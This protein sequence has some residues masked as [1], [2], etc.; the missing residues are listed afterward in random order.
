M[1]AQGVLEELKGHS[2]S[3]SLRSTL[4]PEVG[5]ENRRAAPPT[6]GLGVV[7]GLQMP[8]LGFLAA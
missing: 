7:E 6:L 4:L 8:A 3:P 2:W 1:P 5:A